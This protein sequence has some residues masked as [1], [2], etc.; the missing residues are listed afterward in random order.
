MV[1][2]VVTPIGWDGQPRPCECCPSWKRFVR[3]LL[4]RPDTLAE[5]VVLLLRWAPVGAVAVWSWVGR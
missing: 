1:A 3:R 2:H 5:C 4:R